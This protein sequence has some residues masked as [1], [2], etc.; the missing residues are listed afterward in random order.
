[1]LQARLHL[2]TYLCVHADGG[3]MNCGRKADD[4]RQYL[5]PESLK[6]LGNAILFT[7]ER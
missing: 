3:E 7:P 4:R 5:Q 1:M 2:Q 6:N